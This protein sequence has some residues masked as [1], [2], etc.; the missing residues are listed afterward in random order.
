MLRLILSVIVVFGF[1]GNSYAAQN[2]KNLDQL[3]YDSIHFSEN[4]ND[5]VVELDKIKEYLQSGANPNWVN[6]KQKRSQTVLSR[7]VEQTSISRD[8]QIRGKGYSAIK[9][10][11]DNGAKI[12]QLIDNQ[13]LFWPVAN[14]FYDLTKLLLEKGVSA[15]SWPKSIGTGL[16]PIEYA[17]KN[18]HKNIVDLLSEYGAIKVD[19]KDIIQSRFIE[20]AKFGTVSE[21][22][23]LLKK[24]ARLNTRNKD[25]ETALINA[26]IGIIDNSNVKKVSYLLS[27]GADPNYEGNAVLVSVFS[28]PLHVATIY[29]SFLFGTDKRDH[30]PG[31]K[32]IQL[33]LENGAYVS[34]K[35]QNGLTPLHYAAKYNNIFAAHLF[36]IKGSKVMSRDNE[37]K[38]PL[39][40]AESAEIIKL[41]KE[42]GA[43]EI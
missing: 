36:L 1:S 15:K 9:L 25:R 26:M 19:K 38:T 23:E 16:T 11:F 41:L 20:V 29:T 3:L 42:Y 5:V 14:G 2:N 37:G 4:G 12:Q 34:G 21:L 43:R 31:K 33:L 8:Q 35:D 10:L 13:I 40:Y 32:I 30:E 18:G 17:A 22:D 28:P 24:G 39:D 27:N 6:S 7:F